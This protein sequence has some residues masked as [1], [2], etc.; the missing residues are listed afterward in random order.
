LREEHGLRF[1]KK[2]VLR[3][4]EPKWKKT[5]RGEYC[6]MMNFM[7]SILYRILL[8][9]LINED[10]FGGTC[11]T[12]GGG[13]RYL[14]GFWLGDPKRR[15]YWEDLDAGGTVTLRWILGRYVSMERSGLDWLRL[16]ELGP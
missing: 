5:D 9:R 2:R 7:T 8:G 12:H 3:T 6:I 13:E 4:F 15:D 10:E 16:K 14:W 11:G 1:F